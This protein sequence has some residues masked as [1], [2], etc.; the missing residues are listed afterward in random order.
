[1]LKNVCRM[2]SRI[3]QLVADFRRDRRGIAAVE[4]AMLLPLMLTLYLG[5]VE[6]SQAVSVDRKVSLTAR[7][8][9]DLVAQVAQGASINNADM[10]NIMNAAKAVAA[11]FPDSK[12]KVIVSSVKIDANKK[13]TIEWSDGF[14]TTA[15]AKD[16]TVSVPDGL[17]IPNT[18]LVWSE[19]SYAYTPT[20]GYVITGTLNLKD[21]IYMRA[22][23][24]P[25]SQGVPRQTT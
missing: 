8:V 15:R 10:S 11:P 20:I 14:H 1:M 18:W 2:P 9:A 19:V 24:L 25:A 6:V 21:Q 16:S 13:A 22:R 7:A 12:L 4:F 17:L 3:A 5:G 23:N